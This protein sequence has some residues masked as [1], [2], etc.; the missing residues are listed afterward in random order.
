MKKFVWGV[1]SVLIGTVLVAAVGVGF[2]SQQYQPPGGVEVAK[3]L[4]TVTINGKTVP[5]VQLS[6]N[7]YTSAA[8]AVPPSANLT[9][10]SSSGSPRISGT[11]SPGQLV[12][13]G[14]NPTWPAYGPGTLYQV[15]QGA[16]VTVKWIQYDS[17]GVVNNPYFAAVHGNVG[18]VETVNGKVATGVDANNMAHTF[19]LRAEPGVDPGYLVSVPSPVSKLGNNPVNGQGG[20]V[21][22]F[23][24]IAG[25]KGSYTWNCEFPCGLS[26]AGFGAVMSSYGYM[27]GYLNVV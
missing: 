16:L 9:T 27:S 4:G 2:N 26:I 14:G 23:S 20:Q 13:P 21:V 25:N 8:G 1:I 10:S 6:I 5:H 11:I 17:G 22:Q 7:T 12:H 15:P 18:N 19:T 24:F 3:S